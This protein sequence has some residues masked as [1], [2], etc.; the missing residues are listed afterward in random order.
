MLLIAF[1]SHFATLG[2]IKVLIGFLIIYIVYYMLLSSR[3]SY[4]G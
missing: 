2:I 1:G 3:L 4:I